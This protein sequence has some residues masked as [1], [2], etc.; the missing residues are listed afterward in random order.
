MFVVLCH[1]FYF[2]TD[3]FNF[4]CEY[5]RF[6]STSYSRMHLLN[7]WVITCFILLQSACACVHFVLFVFTVLVV[8]WILWRH[9]T[10]QES[11]VKHNPTKSPYVLSFPVVLGVDI[12]APRH[13]WHW[14]SHCT[15]TWAG[16]QNQWL[17]EGGWVGGSNPLPPEIPKFWQSWVEFPVLWKIHP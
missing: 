12:K 5:C 14:F 4:G 7:S 11:T 8:E 2:L 3:D 15:A 13:W 16:G 1:D 17:T 10:C 9:A 6:V